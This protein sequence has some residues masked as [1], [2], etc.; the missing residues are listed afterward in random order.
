MYIHRLSNHQPNIIKNMP[1]SINRRFTDISSDQEAFA[2]ASPLYDASSSSSSSKPCKRGKIG[3]PHKRLLDETA[4][5]FFDIRITHTKAN[6]LSSSQPVSQLG[7]HER[8][9]KRQY[10]ECVNVIDRGTFTPL[11]FSTTGMVGR[12]GSRCLKSLV[13]LITEKN[14]D[15]SYV[16]V[17]NH[18]RCMLSF[19]LLRWNI[20]CLCGCRASYKR[21]KW[22]C[23]VSEC[24]MLASHWL[25]CL[26]LFIVPLTFVI[27]PVFSSVT[28]VDKFTWLTWFVFLF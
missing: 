12:D 14:V 16:D 24:R 15:L 26:L 20:T 18:P 4:G 10:A 5:C 21:N 19:C 25:M 9:K 23:F 3:H 7:G 1:A 6:L 11:V 13:S 2:K 28:I 27:T 8:E 17:M 22:H